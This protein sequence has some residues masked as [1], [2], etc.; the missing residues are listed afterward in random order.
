[1]ALLL[2]DKSYLK[3]DSNGNYIIYKNKTARA[4]EKKLN[5]KTVFDKYT[6]LLE[7]NKLS[8]E[9]LYYNIDAANHYFEI[10][11]ESNK[12]ARAVQ[13]GYANEEFPIMAEFF[14]NIKDSIPTIISSGG[15]GLPKKNMTTEEVYEFIK[16]YEIFG[17][18]DEVKDV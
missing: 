9:L 3:I 15:I 14:P 4:K 1:M 8:S 18:I 11:D 6:Q 7:E 13:N 2:A 12:Y 16:R 10:L 17:K 5:H